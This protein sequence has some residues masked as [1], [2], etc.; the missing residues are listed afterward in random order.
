MDEPTA[1]T[2]AQL[3]EE[4]EE[5]KVDSEHIQGPIERACVLE[6]ST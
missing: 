4:V 6:K 2:S 3:I 5:E 1:K